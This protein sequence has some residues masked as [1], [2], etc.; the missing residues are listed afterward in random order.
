MRVGLEQF[1]FK[2]NRRSR[3]ALL[4]EMLQGLWRIRFSSWRATDFGPEQETRRRGG[5]S[6][7][8]VRQIQGERHTHLKGIW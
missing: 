2:R 7:R 1:L 4:L 6:P 3:F 8:A 5:L